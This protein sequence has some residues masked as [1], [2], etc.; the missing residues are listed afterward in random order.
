MLVDFSCFRDGDEIPDDPGDRDYN[1]NGKSNYGIFGE[2][3]QFGF[4]F[5]PYFDFLGSGMQRIKKLGQG[6]IAVFLIV[7]DHLP[8]QNIDIR[9]QVVPEGRRQFCAPAGNF[10]DQRLP[11]YRTQCIDVAPDVDDLPLQ[12]FR[13]H[14]VPRAGILSGHGHRGHDVVLH[15][16][17]NAE[18]DQDPMPGVGVEYDVRRFYVPVAKMVLEQ[19]LQ[20]SGHILQQNNGFGPRKFPLRFDFLSQALPGDEFHHHERT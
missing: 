2:F 9:R 20:C 13:R 7:F 3:T 16:F 4:T 1:Q 12:L 6:L 17:R 14:V 19:V 18:V 11:G 8:D 5:F 10:P 15:G